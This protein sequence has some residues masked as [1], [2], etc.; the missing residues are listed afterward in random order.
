MKLK[1]LIID[2]E[3]AAIRTLS[4]MLEKFCTGVEIVG[5]AGTLAEAGNQ[6]RSCKPDLLLLDI[7]MQE[8]SGFDVLEKL[9]EPAPSIIF[10]TAHQQ[11][12]IQAIKKGAK[13]YILKPVDPDELIHA[14]E[15]VRNEFLANKARTNPGGDLINLHTGTSVELL[16][17][18]DILYVKGEGRYSEFYCLDSRKI[19]VC[20]NLGEY[21]RELGPIGFF[22]A[23]KSVLV[24]MMHVTSYGKNDSTVEMRNGTVLPLSRRKKAEFMNRIGKSMM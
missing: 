23:H 8:H 14:V 12:A 17:K 4:M 15:K 20:R 3:A 13:D 10:V 21:E 1:I 2:D 9:D 18:E 6:I 16:K 22:R 7:E 19:V 11:Y 5:T 24:N